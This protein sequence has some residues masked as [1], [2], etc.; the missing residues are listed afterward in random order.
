MSARIGAMRHRLQLEQPITTPD[1]AGGADIA[2]L[3]VASL[4][5]SLRPLSANEVESGDGLVSRI[6]HEVMTRHRT[7]V[8][9]AMRFTAGARVFSIRSVIDPFET[10][11]WLKFLVEENTI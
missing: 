9:A 3:P 11:V 6:T 8:T 2:W 4:W 1:D 5:A 7:D 10:G